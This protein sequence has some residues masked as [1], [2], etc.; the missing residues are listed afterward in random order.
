MQIVRSIFKINLGLYLIF[1][2]VALLSINDWQFNSLQYA[3]GMSVGMAL[4][5]F[6][7]LSGIRQFYR[8]KATLKMNE[9]SRKISYVALVPNVAG[10]ILMGL[11][12]LF[13][14]IVLFLIG[15]AAEFLAWMLYYYFVPRQINSPHAMT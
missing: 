13:P 7:V 15:T 12:A 14:S 8:F 10:F 3:V 5:I 11:G 9:K 2:G 6:I 4:A 1:T